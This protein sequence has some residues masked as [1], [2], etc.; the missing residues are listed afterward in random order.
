LLLGRLAAVDG[1]LDHVL[2]ELFFTGAVV[3]SGT[4]VGGDLVPRWAGIDVLECVGVVLWLLVARLLAAVGLAAAIDFE[5]VGLG[6]DFI[7]R[8]EQIG[9]QIVPVVSAGL[10][11]L[12]DALD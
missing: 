7:A 11:Y 10:E 12:F 2:D 5:R 3:R 8:G 4:T 9:R 1:L 6:E